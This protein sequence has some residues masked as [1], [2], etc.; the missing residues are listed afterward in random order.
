M[1][2]PAGFGTLLTTE[3]CLDW[4]TLIQHY[5]G[6]TR[7]LDWTQSPLVAL[8]FAVRQRWDRDGA[9]WAVHAVKLNERGDDRFGP[10]PAS[11][12]ELWRNE[13]PDARVYVHGTNRPTD[14][15]IAQQGAFSVGHDILV[16]HADSIAD[17]LPEVEG[18]LMLR[19]RFVIPGS[20]KPSFLRQLH[21]MNVTAA[22]LFPGL[23]GLGSELE[24]LARLQQHR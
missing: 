8:Y 19:R 10:L 22:A 16:D 1:V 24:E 20:A 12:A 13:T 15:M 23:D 9:V 6:P 3:A 21:H 5:G 2:L 18:G 4:W 17:L 11:D 14:R 7:I